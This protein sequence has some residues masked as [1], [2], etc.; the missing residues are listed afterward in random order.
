[1][2]KQHVHN[3]RKVINKKKERKIDTNMADA[4]F[5]KQI[6]FPE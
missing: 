6:S 4:K 5:C 2:P 1:M 3:V